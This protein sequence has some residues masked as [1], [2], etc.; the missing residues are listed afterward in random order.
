MHFNFTCIEGNIGVGKTTL[1]KKLSEHF[2]AK[3][4]YEEFNKTPLL[5][6]FYFNPEANA[7]ALESFFLKDRKKQL[8][9]ITKSKSIQKEKKL[10]SDYCLDKCLIFS[11]INLK[12]EQFTKYKKLHEEISETVI[13]PDLV[14]V[15]HSTTDNL[16]RNIA[17]RNRKFEKKIKYTYL[18]KLKNSL[19]MRDPITF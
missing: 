6:R 13:I 15:I 5:S 10:F 4:L 3:A 9:K 12:K 8:L 16:V 7:L 1:V 19:K 17:L 14:I 2:K 18:E 11:K